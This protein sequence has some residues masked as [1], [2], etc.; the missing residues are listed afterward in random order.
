MFVLSLK[1]KKI[2]LYLVSIL[3]PYLSITSSV[4]AAGPVVWVEDG[5][6]RVFKT[7]PAKTNPTITL[8]SAKNEYEP[9][10]IVVKA[11]S[12]NSLSNVNLTVSNLTGP[13]GAVIS[14]NNITLYREHY[15]F[16]TQGSKR[17]NGETNLPLGSGWYPDALIPFKDPV[18]GAD[19]TGQLDAVPFNLVAGQNQPVWVDI[20][21]PAN[22]PAGAY[23]GTATITSAQGSATVNI[24]H[25]VWNFTLPKKNSLKGNS[26]VYAVAPIHI[27]FGLFSKASFLTSSKSIQPSFFTW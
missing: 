16:V 27:I 4:L 3:L 18:T 20:Y 21:A 26:L 25:N 8:Y 23:Q 22:T 15:L 17:Y 10:Q 12:S 19:L 13:N 7:D 5:M 11:P 1:F 2:I 14:S 6:T 24:I 9:F